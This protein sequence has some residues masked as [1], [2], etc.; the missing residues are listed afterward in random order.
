MDI[1]SSKFIKS[2]ANLSQ[3]DVAPFPEIAVIGRSNVGKS[4]LIN[5]LTNSK[6]L[7]RTSSTPGKTRLVNYFLINDEFY[8]VDLPGYGYAKVSKSEQE[9]WGEMVEGYLVNSPNLVH[10]FLLMDIRREPND[11]DLQMAWWSQH[12]NVPVTIIATKVDKI[13]KSKRKPIASKLSDKLRMTF[14]TET[15]IYSTLAKVGKKEVLDRIDNILA[16]I[17]IVEDYDETVN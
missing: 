8:F 7:C 12:Y 3:L 2:A 13:T 1:K 5:N 6:K 14:K 16:N 11:N 15:I 9:K 17:Q 10:I 4:T